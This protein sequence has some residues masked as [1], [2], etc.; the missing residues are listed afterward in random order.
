MYHHHLSL[1]TTI[2]TKKIQGNLI[3]SYHTCAATDVDFWR[4]LSLLIGSH[5]K[6]IA[7]QKK[8]I[9]DKIRTHMSTWHIH[10]PYILILFSMILEASKVVCIE[11][12]EENKQSIVALLPYINSKIK[13]PN[14]TLKVHKTKKKN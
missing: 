10:L 14:R 4:I 7:H 2:N 13:E 12:K 5:S 3:L 1:L 9:Q 11:F 8:L 6:Q